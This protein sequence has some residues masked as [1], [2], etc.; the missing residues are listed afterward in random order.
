MTD[1][2]EVRTPYF[3]QP[4]QLCSY[5]LYLFLWD[6]YKVLDLFFFTVHLAT[7]SDEAE[8]V[9]NKALRTIAASEEEK[10]RYEVGEVSRNFEKMADFS[11]LNSKNITNNIVDAFLWY[12]STMIQESM[13]K[14]PELIKSGETIKI[15]EVFE[16]KSRRDLVNYLIDRKINSLSYG[17]M[18]AIETFIQ[19]SLGVDVFHEDEQRT[20]MKIFI[21][22]RNVNAH[23]RGRANRLF[24]K[25]INKDPRFK[26]EEGKTT[27]LDYDKIVL[28]S[29]V[30]VNTALSL[31]KQI[32]KKFK[33]KRKRYS[34][35]EA[36]G[37]MA[38]E[39]LVTDKTPAL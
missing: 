15:E 13:K 17:G 36:A 12:I 21:E 22:I 19:E 9:I 35:W 18:K 11:S 27:F 1:E 34:T 37:K 32:S 4:A 38:R 39:N 6:Y 16:Y 30:C 24:M 8:T 28:L 20:L 33:I 7:R 5:P 31:D 23:N 25:R 26:F 3:P 2:S 29:D 10:K 14:R